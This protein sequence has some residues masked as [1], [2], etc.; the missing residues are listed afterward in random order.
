MSRCS[1]WRRLRA[2]ACPGSPRRSPSYSYSL[3]RQMSIDD[4]PLLIPR[5][6]YYICI[7]H[8][9]SNVVAPQDDHVYL[10]LPMALVVSIGHRTRFSRAVHDPFGS[11][12]SDAFRDSARMASSIMRT[13]I[14]R[15]AVDLDARSPFESRLECFQYHGQPRSNIRR[16]AVDLGC[17]LAF[18]KDIYWTARGVFFCSLSSG[19]CCIDRPSARSS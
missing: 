11:C 17:I 13:L 1:L 2:R 9:T 3:G 19:T 10:M 7:N 14:V 8:G 15:N 12:R 6:G 16:E 18:L 5:H 4:M